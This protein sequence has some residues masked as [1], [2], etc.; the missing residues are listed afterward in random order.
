[1]TTTSQ[2]IEKALSI[3]KGHDWYWAMADYSNPAYGNAYA[4][5]RAFVEVVA[6][7]ADST[8]VTALRD[9]W[10]ATYQYVHATMWCSSVEAKETFK[11]KESE[12]MAVIKPAYSIAA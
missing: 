10:K 7:I 8:I 6:S 12:L 11:T 5:M 3:L 4:S 2:K 1:M 9:L